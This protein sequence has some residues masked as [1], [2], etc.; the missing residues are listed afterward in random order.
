MAFVK[1]DD[2]V[3]AFPR[4]SRSRARRKDSATVKR[5]CRDQFSDSH[6]RDP[7]AEAE[8]YEASRSRSTKLGAVSH[9]NASITCCESHAAVGCHVTYR[10]A[11]AFYDR[12]PRWIIKYSSRNEADTAK[13]VDGGDADCFVA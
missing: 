13:N 1:D 2:V 7:L 12:E 3:K 5:W 8:P 6:R 10:T 9:G 4:S 11:Q